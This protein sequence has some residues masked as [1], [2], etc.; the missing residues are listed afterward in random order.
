MKK[1]LIN[2]EKPE[3]RA[4][5]EPSPAANAPKS[6]A[7][8]KPATPP[9]A[10]LEEPQAEIPAT[11]LPQQKNAELAAAPEPVLETADGRKRVIIEKVTPEID[12]GQFPIK[13]TVGEIVV[14]EADV[15]TD[16]HDSLSCILQY[17]KEGDAD[18]QEAPMRPLVNDRWRGEFTVEAMGRYQ[19]TVTAWTDAFKS[20]R[21]DLGRWVEAEDI[22]LALRTGANLVGKTSQCATGE[23]AKWLA[24]RAAELISDQDLQQRRLLGLD[25]KLAQTMERNADRTLA[26]SYGQTLGVVVDDE[27]ARFSAWYEL[28]PRSCAPAPGKHGTFKDCEVWLPRIAEMGFN[29]VYF[30]PIHPV[31]RV[32]RKGKNNTLTPGPDD[33]GSPWAIGA[34]EGGHKDILPELGTLADF[35]RLVQKAKEHGL[36]IALDIALQCAPD[37]PYVQQHPD[38]FRWRPDGTVQYAENPPK[39]YQDIYPFNFETADWRALWDEIKS[40]FE[41]WIE[42]GVRIFRVDNPHTKPFAMWEWLITEVKKTTP[43][44]IFLAEAFTRPKVMHRLAKLGYTQSYTYYA[45]RNTKWELIEYLTELTQTQSREYFRPN[46]WPNTPDILTEALQFGGRP[47]FISRLVLAATLTANYGI[48]G[49][50][51]E[52]MEH[53]AVKHG[54][55]EYLDS[56]KYQIRYRSFEELNGPNS[57]CDFITLVN[58]IRKHNPAL[59]YNWNL[60]FHQTDNEQMICYS[61]TTADGANIILVVVN[62][63]PN[64]TQAGFTQLDLQGLG[65]DPDQPFQVHDLLTGASYIWHGSRNYVELNPHRMPAHVFQVRSGSHSERD[66]EPFSG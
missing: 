12:G 66:F 4:I 42:Q 27:R 35:R 48:Y 25:E 18:W 57:L 8:A 11:N 20:W 58:R 28:F 46:F 29:V 5:T 10:K 2:Q 53:V 3:K 30:P 50:A 41:F 16:G 13:R 26:L 43:N 62:L 24:Q 23:D 49:P 65:V 14:V 15:F 32:N 38:W 36:E 56:E 17:R 55:E 1:P 64:Y 47:A 19:Y 34:A 37:H 31:G 59:H 33:V 61:K 40:I 21:H 7:V 63:D 60:I 52:M 54:S 45:W 6:A 9:E 39:K 51:F 22:A 44:A